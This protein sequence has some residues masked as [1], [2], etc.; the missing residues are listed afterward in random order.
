MYASSNREEFAR[1][2]LIR[3]IEVIVKR[4]EFVKTPSEK[5]MIYGLKSV[6]EEMA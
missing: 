3:N 1:N 6:L 2:I 5:E 4:R